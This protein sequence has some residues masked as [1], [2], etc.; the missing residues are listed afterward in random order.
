MINAVTA[1]QD[2]VVVKNFVKNTIHV[3][4]KID[5]Q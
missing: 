1:A 4:M 3:V 5:F 2:V